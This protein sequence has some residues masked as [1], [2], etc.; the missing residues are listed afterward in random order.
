MHPFVKQ[1]FVKRG[2]NSAA[3]GVYSVR[4]LRSTLYPDGADVVQS[5]LLDVAAL[6]GELQA[7]SLEVLLLEHGHLRKTEGVFL[8]L[9]LLSFMSN[10]DARIRIRN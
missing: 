6:R 1:I 4:D 8:L 10:R 9:F 3:V 2:V 7:L 5:T